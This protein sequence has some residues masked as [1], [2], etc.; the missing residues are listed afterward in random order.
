MGVRELTG[1]NKERESGMMIREGAEKEE[2]YG[3]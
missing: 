3:E 2:T 1:K